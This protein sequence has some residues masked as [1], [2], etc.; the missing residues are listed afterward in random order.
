MPRLETLDLTCELNAE[1][2]AALSAGAWPRLRELS[3]E[4]NDINAAGAAG[5]A[6]GQWPELQVLDLAVNELRSEGLAALAS[7][8]WQALLELHLADNKIGDEGV[9]AL[10]RAPLPQLQVLNISENAITAR[11]AEALAAAHWPR[12]QRLRVGGYDD[13]DDDDGPQL[14]DAGA[15]ALAQGAWPELRELTVTYSG[16]G[17]AGVAALMRLAAA[18]TQLHTVNLKG[19][20]AIGDEG[21]IV[22]ARERMP[23]LRTLNLR[24]CGVGAAGAVAL[25]AAP[26]AAHIRLLWIDVW[27]DDVGSGGALALTPAAL[28]AMQTL[29]IYDPS[30]MNDT[31]MQALE[32]GW[33]IAQRPWTLQ[34]TSEL[35]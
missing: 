28:P 4:S 21:V 29:C 32:L 9:I 22:M 3:L 11:G 7:A 18:A 19:N 13:D 24:R 33:S 20:L 34:L 14:G 1:A 30:R 25:V 23:A 27:D 10:A 35:H 12:L 8:G 15:Q 6:Q 2:A 26:W 5:I 31:Y 16:L 17:P